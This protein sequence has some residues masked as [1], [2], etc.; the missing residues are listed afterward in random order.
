MRMIDKRVEVLTERRNKVQREWERIGSE[1][2]NTKEDLRQL[3]KL[4]VP[5]CLVGN[6]RNITL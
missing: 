2:K 1:M 6:E 5:S 4:P 3:G